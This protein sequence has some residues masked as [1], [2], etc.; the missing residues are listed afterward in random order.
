MA[1]LHDELKEDIYLV[2]PKGLIGNEHN[3]LIC[4]LNRSLYILK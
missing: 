4:K 1:F 2:Q 3:N